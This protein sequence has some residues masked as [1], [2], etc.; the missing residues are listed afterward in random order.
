MNQTLSPALLS[1]CAD[2]VAAQMEEEGFLVDPGL[3]ELILEQEREGSLG[4]LPSSHVEAAPR[5]LE[6]LT[7]AGVRGVPEAVNE[8]LIIAVLEWED[9]FLAL[10][11]RPRPQPR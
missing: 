7:A 11:G 2:W 4:A 9:E 5:L 1:E 8:R 3:V 10:A 6:L